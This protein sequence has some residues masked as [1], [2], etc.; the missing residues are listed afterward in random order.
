VSRKVVASAGGVW[1]VNNTCDVLH[2]ARS[3]QFSSSDVLEQ[4]VV[5]RGLLASNASSSTATPTDLNKAYGTHSGVTW[6]GEESSDVLA[7]TW[8][9]DVDGS[10]GSLAVQLKQQP[11]APRYLETVLPGDILFVFMNDAGDYDPNNRFAGTLVAVAVVD[12]VGN[13]IHVQQGATVEIVNVTARD[14]TVIFSESSTV[15]DQAF[16]Q[17]ENAAYT[18]EFIR[19]LFNDQKQLALSP[20]E[21]VLTLIRLL[22]DADSTGSE[23]A[24]LQWKLTASGSDKSTTQL[25]SLVDVT[26]YVQNPLPFYATAEP[27]GIVQAGNVWSLLESY[28]NPVVNEFFVDVRD[29]TSQEQEFRTLTANAAE[30][31]FFSS[32]QGDVGRQSDTVRSLLDSAL[33]RAT[34]PQQL[35][36]TSVVALV[37]RQRP[38]DD[39]AFSALPVNEVDVTEVESSE[40]ARSSHDVLNWFRL[41]FPGL[42]LKHQEA[43]SGIYAMPISVAKFGYRRM[44][45][46][47]RYMFLSSDD[48]VTFSKDSTKVDF[49]DVF[50]K[51]VDLLVR[52][53][54][55]N[56]VWYAGSMTTRFKPSI[57]VGTRLRYTRASEV[58][59][60]Y[61]QGVQHSFGK[62]PGAS[63]STFTLTRGRLVS[64]ATIPLAPVGVFSHDGFNLDRGTQ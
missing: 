7:C 57:R 62:E 28:A 63:R 4:I 2:V 22:Y 36:G 17:I 6:F 29:I 26:T 27:P 50:R 45:A 3:A 54:G 42:D 41:R 47:T 61:V 46:E 43:V 31:T 33:F 37:M 52:W 13:P 38:Y 64:E 8:S 20:L 56:E 9:K 15:F 23:G 35:N 1:D 60:F 16:T 30:S 24:R 32:N 49:G 10:P 19:Q 18:G 34:T 44:D 53:Y 21:N 40:I 5:A 12:R 11:G 58:R 39:D 14:F 25:V 48:A 59:D 51:Y 55:Q